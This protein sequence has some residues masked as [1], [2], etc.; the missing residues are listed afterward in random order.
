MLIGCGAAVGLAAVVGLVVG[1]W[2]AV[3]LGSTALVGGRLGR[4]VGARVGAIDDS[5]RTCGDGR[6]LEPD[7]PAG[8]D[9]GL[10]QALSSRMG[11]NQ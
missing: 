8:L 7:R 9:T 1:A 3:G 10:L 4:A 2:V 5:V 6:L 11:I